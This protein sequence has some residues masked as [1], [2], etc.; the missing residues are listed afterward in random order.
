MRFGKT[1]SAVAG[2][3]TGLIV[4]FLLWG[5]PA[6]DLNWALTKTKGELLQTQAWLRDEIRSSDERLEQVS[7]TLT[8]ALAELAKAQAELARNRVAVQP[9][10]LV[11]ASPGVVG[12]L[13]R[14]ARQRGRNDPEDWVL[15][16]DAG[17]A[18]SRGLR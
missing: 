13:V 7:A 16:R 8:K 9:S 2:V 14:G 12:G 17:E 18:I 3:V 10:V 11:G 15:R 4:G 6:G 5:L 1:L